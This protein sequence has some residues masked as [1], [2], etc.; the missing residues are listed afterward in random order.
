MRISVARVALVVSLVLLAACDAL[1]AKPNRRVELKTLTGN[2]VELLPTESQLPYCLLFSLSDQGVL[3]QLTMTHENKS[4]P[5]EAGKPIGGVSYRVPI[6]EGRVRLLAFFSDRKL[7]AGSV[8]QQIYELRET[9]PRFMPYDLRLPGEVFAEFIEFVPKEGGGTPE[10]TVAMGTVLDAGMTAPATA[11]SDGGVTTAAP[12][13]A[14]VLARADAG[15]PATAMGDAGTA[16]TPRADAGAPATARADAGTATAARPDAG[17]PIAP[18]VD[19]G[20]APPRGS[21]GAGADAGT[22]L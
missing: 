1:P 20:S 5:C 19:A 7:N 15:T 21:S 6:E 4:V 11:T 18:R 12:G 13:D 16:A 14:G 9:N 8:A 17:T 3:R 10:G 2:T 22:A